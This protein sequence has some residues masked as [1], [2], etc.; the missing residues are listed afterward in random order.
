MLR[1]DSTDQPENRELCV[2]IPFNFQRHLRFPRF[3]TLLP[4]AISGPFI[5]RSNNSCFPLVELLE[6]QN[7]LN[8]RHC[9]ARFRIGFAPTRIE[10]N[11]RA[12]VR[13]AGPAHWQSPGDIIPSDRVLGGLMCLE[14]MFVNSQRS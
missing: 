8:C 11:E 1:L 9:E 10:P 5:T 3:A 13:G 2:R 7:L 12:E 4:N 14:L 6:L